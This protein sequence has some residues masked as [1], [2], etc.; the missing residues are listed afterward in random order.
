MLF[1]ILTIKSTVKSLAVVTFRQI[2]IGMTKHL[3][4][5]IAAR[6]QSTKGIKSKH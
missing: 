4:T 3:A 1:N 2:F 6:E 5:G